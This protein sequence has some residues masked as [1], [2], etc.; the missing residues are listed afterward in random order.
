MQKLNLS[1]TR[2][3]MVMLSVVLSVFLSGCSSDGEE[4]PEYMD[5]QSVKHLEVPPKL[6][7]PDTSGAMKLP[8]PSA[9]AQKAFENYK[10][11]KDIIIAPSFDG[12]R[13]KNDGRL[14]WLEI[15][16]PVEKLW[17][18]L[19]GFLAAEGIEVERVEKLMGFI[20]TQWMNEYQVTYN[21][22]D[23]GSGW[24]SGLSRFSPDYKDK[25]RVRV[26]PDDKV[27]KSRMYV[28]H[29]GMQIVVS[30]DVSAWEQRES[31]PFLEREIMYRFMLYLGATKGGATDLLAGYHSYQS[32]VVANKDN[33]STF[34]V[35]GDEASVWTRLNVAMDRLGVDIVNADKRT[36]KLKVLV[37]NLNAPVQSDESGGW[38][39]SLFGRD[40][41]IGEDD[42]GF[43]TTEYKKPEVASEDRITLIVEQQAS[44]HS[45]MIKL[46]LEDGSKIEDGLALD[47]RNALLQQL[48]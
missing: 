14:Y 38:F 43:E 48:K 44:A 15:D 3:L 6:S 8:Q 42:E 9:K 16:Y 39:S 21:S 19:P 40:V 37:G 33:L 20:D 11:G 26:E 18:M 5:T 25:F 41:D 31:E 12:V 4:R 27:G 35:Q 46:S 30:N 22:E 34:N 47:F 13:L 29:R 45:S 32:R 1:F 17:S 10:N 24:F 36:H 7:T 23:E 2:Q 28:S